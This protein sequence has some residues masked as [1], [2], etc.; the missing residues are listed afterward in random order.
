MFSALIT[1]LLCFQLF[2]QWQ[3]V[4]LPT[5]EG[6]NSGCFI[7]DSTGWI[8]GNDYIYKTD[9]QG[10]GWQ[11][12]ISSNGGG[13]LI[14]LLNDTTVFYANWGADDG[15]MMT[16][17]GGTTWKQVDAMKSYYTDMDF[18][19]DQ[20]GYLAGGKFDY[21]CI[22]RKTIDG[23]KTW[24]TVATDFTPGTYEIEGISFISE[25]EGWAVS[26]DAYILHTI[27]GGIN[28]EVQDSIG[29][30]PNY[31]LPLRDIEFVNSDSGWAVGGL[32]GSMIIARTINGG[33]NWTYEESPGSSLQIV[34]FLN[35]KKGWTV[36][37]A[38]PFI[39]E[40][41]DGGMSWSEPTI[42]PNLSG[43]QGF[44]SLSLTK[45]STAWAIGTQ[46][47]RTS[48]EEVTGI[49]DLK[50]TENPKSF[51]LYS[52]YPN[53]FNP[54]TRIP[55]FVSKKEHVRISIFDI[56]GRELQVLLDENIAA[57]N[58]EIEWNSS[59]YSSGVYLCKMQ[60]NG[61][62]DSQKLLLVK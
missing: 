46:L 54:V 55:F 17:D 10:Q 14:Y 39:L 58:H 1:L 21:N 35:S 62:V 36:G 8:V 26:Y 37:R 4:T 22:I 40:T 44:Y 11:Q 27:D 49:E 18:V 53:P 5:E 60:A 23:G 20:I 28:W 29:Y 7:S 41:T 50:L 43:G 13:Q 16:T 31:D 45:D 32:T 57:G 59:N 52:N 25:N 19:S 51:E 61:I 33:K 56:R 2:G 47:Y 15:L 12:Q 3:S 34:K 9:D 38:G 48:L 42:T 6:F 24:T 30:N